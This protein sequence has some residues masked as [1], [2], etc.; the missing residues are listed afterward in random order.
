MKWGNDMSYVWVGI[1]GV[2][3]TWLRFA[4]GNWVQQWSTSTLFPTG[5]LTVNLIGCFALGWFSRWALSQSRIPRH[6]HISISTGLIGSFTTFSALSVEFTQLMREGHVAIGMAYSGASMIGGWCL[7]WL[8][9][10][11]ARKGKEAG[12]RG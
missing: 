6:M 5:T 9:M 10:L 8:G 1:A 7:V 11:L 4:L 3:G 2:I 12:F